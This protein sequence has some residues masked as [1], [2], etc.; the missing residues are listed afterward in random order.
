MGSFVPPGSGSLV[1]PERDSRSGRCRPAAAYI[2]TWTPAGTCPAWTVGYQRTWLRG[3]LLAG[4]T[5]TAYLIPQVMAYAALAGVPAVVGLWAAVGALT[6]YALIGSSPLLSVGPESTTALMTAAALGSVAG[7]TQQPAEFAA[8]LAL[9]VAVLCLL[10]WFGHLSALAQ[11]LSRP[12]LVGYMAGIA[13]IMMLSQAG[14]LTSVTVEGDGV[15]AEALHVLGHLDEAHLPTL[16]LGLGTLAVMLLGSAWRPHA[17][18]RPA[19]H[20][21]RDRRG[22]TPRPAR[23]RACWSSGRSRPACRCP[24]CPPS[25]RTTCCRC[26]HRRWGWPSSATPTTC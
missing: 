23:A 6:A 2:E 3:D 1:S 14:R 5:V 20:A 18:D 11:L 4:V 17:P 13:V 19:R 7:A 15:L 24:G 10:G 12:V 9:V 8:A 26:W 25:R 21:G 16:A 22:G